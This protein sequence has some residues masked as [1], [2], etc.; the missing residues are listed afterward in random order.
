MAEFEIASV[1]RD[2]NVIDLACKTNARVALTEEEQVAVA[3][4]DA[5]AKEIGNTGNDKE[6]QIAQFITKEIQDAFET[7]PSQ[8]LEQMFDVGTLGEDDRAMYYTEPKNTLRAIE[9][10]P[11]GNV[12]RSF[13]DIASVTPTYTNLQ[14]E[15]DISY[16]D[17]R[18]NGWKSVARLSQYAI[19]TLNNKMF[20]NIFDAIDAAITSG[21]NYIDLTSVD[22]ISTTGADKL[23]LYIHDMNEAGGVIVGLSKYMQQ[24]SKLSGYSAFYS[25]DMKNTLYRTGELPTYDG[26]PLYRIATYKY[27]N[28]DG[29]TNLIKDKRVYGVAGK[30][31][32]IDMV[33]DVRTY[34]TMDNNSENVHLK[35]AGFKFARS[36]YNSALDKC[37]K[38]A[39]KP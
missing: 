22:A 21:D 32:A 39:L 16:T 6:H 37:V 20:K 13:L 8:L 33:G 27:L 25:E 30:I 38:M 10:A 14:V 24:L 19:D 11:G 5:W 23:S 31:G 35:I 9:A 36:F 4:L 1:L 17:L 28:G 29:A 15:T 34:E 26:I 18:R 3:T 12:E 7:Y 2:M